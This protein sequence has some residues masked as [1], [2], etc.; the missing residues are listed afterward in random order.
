MDITSLI[1]HEQYYK[2]NQLTLSISFKTTTNCTRIRCNKKKWIWHRLTLKKLFE[3]RKERFMVM[4]KDTLKKRRQMNIFV[5]MG[6][7]HMFHS[8]IT[9]IK[10]QLFKSKMENWICEAM[11]RVKKK[12]WFKSQDFVIQIKLYAWFKSI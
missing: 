9:F 5:Y 8:L 10:K 1:I 6:F 4:C 7:T 3:R 11:V 2:I 12:L